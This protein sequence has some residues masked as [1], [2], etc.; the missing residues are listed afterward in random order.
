VFLRTLYVS[1]P[2]LVVRV[3]NQ[4][5]V[6]QKDGQRESIPLR[7]IH[8]VI[9]LGRVPMTTAFLVACLARKIPVVFLSHRGGYL[10][11][12]SA[13]VTL[14]SPLIRRQ[15]ERFDN[16]D[17]RLKT[18]RVIIGGKIRAQMAFLQSRRNKNEGVPPLI[19]RMGECI[20]KLAGAPT[21]ATLMGYEGHTSRLYFE[22]LGSLFRGELTF[23][24]RRKHPSTDPVNALLSFGYTLLYG[25]IQS[26]LLAHGLDPGL[27]FLHE[28]LPGRPN[29]AMDLIEE[30]RAPV[31]DR[32]VLRTVNTGVFRRD[33]FQK[34][35][36]EGGPCYLE[37]DSR[38]RFIVEYE[39]AMA[40]EYRHKST[41]LKVDVRR[42]ISIQVVCLKKVL[43]GHLPLYI[44]A[45]LE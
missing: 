8:Q 30:L 6:I 9:N 4:N 39:K 7:K 10:G 2:S 3:A 23:T 31:V 21:V 20:P 17:F 43:A 28:S 36:T 42:I 38:K 33:H 13:E 35:R 12:L 16:L 27:G 26:I 11:R 1:D 24:G 15:M 22:A 29:L 5:A 41:N 18:A 45:E 44:P 25:D 37:Q 14:H 19:R 32:L 34:P 40:M